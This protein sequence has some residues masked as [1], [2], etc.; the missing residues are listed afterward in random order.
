MILN[1]AIIGIE[2]CQLVCAH[3]IL[4]NDPNS[5]IHLIS[6]NAEAGLIGELP[7]LITQ[8][9]SNTIP[10]EWIGDLGPQLPTSS[11]TAVRRSWLE[12]AMAT[13]LVERA[14]A[15]T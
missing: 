11:D 4:D 10:N 14:L 12:K 6:E 5:K 13:K 3:R 15:S 2:L 1:L 7:G 9:F 8:P